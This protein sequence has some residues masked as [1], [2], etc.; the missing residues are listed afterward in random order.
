MVIVVEMRESPNGM[1]H[2]Y[3]RYLKRLPLRM[4]YSQVASTLAR[5]DAQLRNKTLA[6]GKKPD[7]VYALDA[8]GV[9]EGVA[10]LIEK[11]LPDADI[12]RR[13]VTG[14]ISPSIDYEMREI[15]L[16]KTQLVSIL[17]A[18]LDS[19]RIYFSSHSKELDAMVEV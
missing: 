15:R 10:D 5:L 7:I 19:D 12:Y 11:K 1:R 2:H 9:G 3:E 6:E 8:T 4:L 13:Y 14:G 18:A 17:V 16:P